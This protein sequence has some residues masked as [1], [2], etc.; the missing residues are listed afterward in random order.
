MS[1]IDTPSTR[2]SFWVSSTPWA[3]NE[4]CWPDSLPPTLTRSTRTPGVWLRM[5]QGSR[6]VGIF[7]SSTWETVVP[8]WSLRSSSSG[9][10]EVTVMVS[11][12]AGVS[13]SSISVLRPTRTSTPG[14]STEPK[15]SSS[16]RTFQAPGSRLRKRACPWELVI[17]S[18]SAPMPPMVTVTPG[19]RSPLASLTV[20]KTLPVGAWAPA[21][22]A[23]PRSATLAARVRASA[24]RTEALGEGRLDFI[25]PPWRCS[26]G[27]PDGTPCTVGLPGRRRINRCAID[28]RPAER[29]PTAPGVGSRASERAVSR[30]ENETPD[31]PLQ[32]SGPIDQKSGFEQPSKTGSCPPE[33]SIR[34]GS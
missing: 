31:A 7:S 32:D 6:A 22:R 34:G 16:A 26:W 5:A 33:R 14:Y 28:R 19:R 8:C 18:L 10:S 12:T 25:S 13:F 30:S 29:T 21:G 27:L 9:D 11:S 24:R 1:V 3:R 17:W 15:P 23:R 4:A 20:T 2:K